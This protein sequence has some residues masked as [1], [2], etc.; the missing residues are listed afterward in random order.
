VFTN[1]AVI[2]TGPARL[3][4]HIAALGP[5]QFL[6]ALFESRDPQPRFRIVLGKAIQ[7]ADQPQAI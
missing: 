1:E 2:T 3:D 7:Q 5:T 4:P 6:Q